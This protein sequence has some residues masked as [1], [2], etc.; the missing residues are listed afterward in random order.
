MPR[1]G[2]KKKKEIE[3]KTENKNEEGFRNILDSM[4]GNNTHI[5]GTPEEAENKQEVKNL[6][7]EIMTENFPNLV[8][9]KDTQVR[10]A[11]SPK[12]GLKEAHTNHNWNG[13]A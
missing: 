2:S 4:R 5:M 8:K 13:K 6:F 1:Q 7:E 11:Q 9:V 3:E 12:R 10:E